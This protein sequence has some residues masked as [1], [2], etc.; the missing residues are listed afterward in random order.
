MLEPN[1]FH[2][3]IVSSYYG[4]W[5]IIQEDKILALPLNYFLISFYFYGCQIYILLRLKTLNSPPSVHNITQITTDNVKFLAL[6]S[7]HVY[8]VQFISFYEKK[9][10][11]SFPRLHLVIF[12]WQWFSM[13]YVYFSETGDFLRNIAI[14]LFFKSQI[15]FAELW[16][17]NQQAK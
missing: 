14:A 7:W 16:Y 12:L 10:I 8:N 4:I 17:A 5:Q 13:K 15:V 11:Q 1:K 3:G 2:V 6:L 9:V